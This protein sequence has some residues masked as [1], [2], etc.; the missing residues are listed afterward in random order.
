VSAS[1]DDEL[2]A[3]LR[4]SRWYLVRDDEV[5]GWAIATADRPTSEINPTASRDRVLFDAVFE[6][7]GRDVVTRH[8]DLLALRTVD[9]HLAA[10]EPPTAYGRP[11]ALD[12]PPPGP[13]SY[14]AWV[15]ERPAWS[16][17]HRDVQHVVR[18]VCHA[19]VV[20]VATVAAP[21]GELGWVTEDLA[22]DVGLLAG[23]RLVDGLRALR[24]VR[25]TATT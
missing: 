6:E 22:S 13:R 21:A 25:P 11:A 12:A 10:G 8:N 15:D 19:Y 3:R 7:L 24:A 5:G 20:R 23:A 18:T 17:L 1:E 14:L 16:G 4:A 2:L 9:D